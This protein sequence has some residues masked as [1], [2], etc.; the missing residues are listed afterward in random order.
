MIQI[1]ENIYIGT[2]TEA[3]DRS[4]MQ[5]RHLT[6]GAILSCTTVIPPAAQGMPGVLYSGIPI[7]DA[8]PWPEKEKKHAVK[9]IREAVRFGK[10]FVHSDLGQSR[11]AAAVYFYLVR[12]LRMS[13]QEALDLLKARHPTGH[14]HPIILTGR[15]PPVEIRVPSAPVKLDMPPSILFPYE[16]SVVSVT[17][18][19]LETVK[20]CVASI[21]TN[22]N[23]P[24]QFIV[25]D[26][27]STDGTAEYLQGLNK[28]I[29]VHLWQNWGKGRAA[30]LGLGMAQGEWV[31]YFDSDIE[32]PPGWFPTMR[33]AYEEIPRVGWLS[34]PYGTTRFKGRTGELKKLS[35][36]GISGGMVFWHSKVLK[37][38]G[39]FP[40]DR[41]YGRVD[42][43][44]AQIA[45][46]KG[47]RVGYVISSKRILH[48]TRGDD[49]EY[50][51]WQ[52]I[53]RRKPQPPPMSRGV[54]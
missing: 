18:N 3:L 8:T 30:N 36:E 25:V 53:Q 40:D 37:Q 26:N 19:R 35:E 52:E 2:T 1:E 11:S 43:D 34:L 7:P 5:A 31:S 45:R 42:I 21:L 39:G 46:G 54:K 41:L 20:R 38:I 29:T 23:R 14:I 15:V 6:F 51:E 49:P 32:V 13:H 12:G 10:V 47:F 50:K 44:Y 4:I 24:F 9:F 27:G 16:L 33:K 22:T 17:W 48:C 28:T